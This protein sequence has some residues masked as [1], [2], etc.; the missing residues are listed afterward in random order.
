MALFCLL[1]RNAKYTQEKG[2]VYE[3]VFLENMW[4]INGVCHHSGT[5]ILSVLHCY[6]DEHCASQPT[7]MVMLVLN[8]MYKPI[9]SLIYMECGFLNF[10]LKLL[11]KTVAMLCPNTVCGQEKL[12]S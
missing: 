5:S 12:N 2:L 11:S 10:S 3:M 8:L 4:N 1:A 6:C 7:E 9:S